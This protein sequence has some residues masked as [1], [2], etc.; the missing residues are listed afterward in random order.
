MKAVLVS[1]TILLITAQS[2]FSQSGEEPPEQ[3]VNSGA[4][5]SESNKSSALRSDSTQID[6]RK[7]LEVIANQRVISKQ[8]IAPESIVLEDNTNFTIEIISS[9]EF[10]VK[11]STKNRTNVCYRVLP[12]TLQKN[13]KITSIGNYDSAAFFRPSKSTNDPLISNK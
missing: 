7:C 4:V 10:I 9:K 3:F 2:L 6:N 11:S 8:V 13:F 12:K 5:K 1:I